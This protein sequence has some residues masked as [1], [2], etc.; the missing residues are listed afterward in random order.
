MAMEYG[1]VIEKMRS[2]IN[3]IVIFFEKIGKGMGERFG[4]KAKF[5]HKM[6]FLP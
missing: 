2:Q 4:A 6:F 1:S 5:F 3:K